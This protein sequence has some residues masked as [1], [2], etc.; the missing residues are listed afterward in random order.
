MKVLMINSF[1]YLRGGSE[2]CFFDLMALL[3]AHGHEVIP[4]SMHH[5]RNRPTPYADYFISNIDFPQKLG[6]GSSLADK[7]SAVERVLYSREAR[8]QIERLIADTR[9]DVA[10]VHGIAHETSPSILPALQKAGVPVVQTLHDYKLLCP[11]TNF[12]SQ[13]EVC[14]RCRGHRYY[15]V[16]RYRCKRDSLPASLLAGLEMSVHKALQIYERNVD[17]F[18]APSQFL[19]QKLLEYGIGNEVVHL[20]NAI[21]VDS[22]QPCY[23][24]DDYFVYVGRLVSVKGI[25]TLLEAMRQVPNGRL[26]IAGGGEEE[27]A[28]QAFAREHG[29]HNVQFLG[30]LDAAELIPLIQNA[31]FTVVPSEWYENY[32]MTVIESLACGTPVL[33]ANIGGIGEQIE[34]GR[35]GLLFE[36]G[37]AAEL[38]EKINWLL[39]H[40]DEAIVMGRRGRAQV[41]RVNHPQE[42]YR[43]TI[44]IYERLLARQERQ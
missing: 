14:E 6:G 33:G 10:H 41:E 12:V 23:Q 34:D 13:G 44:A 31:A 2:R 40:R 17:V 30:H 4:F 29:L 39:A 1:F 26:L 24:P 32:S 9:P 5:E 25:R 42:H 43:Q 19:R 8:R 11:N 18:I 16:V 20:P 15:N 22:F 3:E 37:S 38:A 27:G 36:S 21:D 28:L 7:L 35:N